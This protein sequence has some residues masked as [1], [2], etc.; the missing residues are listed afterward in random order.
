MS[1]Y[2][3]SGGR[4]QKGTGDVTDVFV[5]VE[6]LRSQQELGG[7]SLADT[8]HARQNALN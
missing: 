2:F 8:I 5:D 1:N 6:Q 3:Q 4:F 7:R